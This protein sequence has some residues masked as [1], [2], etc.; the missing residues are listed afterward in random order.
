MA[1]VNPKNEL[2]EWCHTHKLPLPD[3]EYRERKTDKDTL[4][5]ARVT[6]NDVEYWGME[7]KTKKRDRYGIYLA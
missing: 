1:H 5:R 7:K 6:V 4:Y 3:Y 2:Q